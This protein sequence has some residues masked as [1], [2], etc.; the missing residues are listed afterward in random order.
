MQLIVTHA[1]DWLKKKKKILLKYSVSN[2]FKII[3]PSINLT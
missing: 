2:D 1:S 3:Y